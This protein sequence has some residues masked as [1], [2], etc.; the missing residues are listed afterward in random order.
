MEIESSLIE[1]EAYHCD[2]ANERHFV[3]VTF[4][5]AGMYINSFAVMPSKFEN[6]PLWVQPPKHRQRNGYVPT[7]DFDK[8]YPLWQIVETKSR[9]AVTRCSNCSDKPNSAGKDTVIEEI[10][11]EPITLD[12]IPF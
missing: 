8:S 10:P 11:E 9:E 12:D 2:L 3:K 1:A 4:L 6:Q 7:V 5:G